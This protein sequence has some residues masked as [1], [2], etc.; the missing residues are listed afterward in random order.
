MSKNIARRRRA[1]RTTNKI[2]RGDKPCLRVHR[3]PTHIYAQ[4]LQ[5]HDDG[6]DVIVSAST[7]EKELRD[8]LSGSPKEKAHAIGE[9]VAKRAADKG[10][11]VVSFHRSGFRYH[12]RVRALAEGAREAGLE[13]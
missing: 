13:F 7:L 10:V 2:M 5:Y 8:K 9:T 11:K 3:T 12:G 6:C 1:T 4:V